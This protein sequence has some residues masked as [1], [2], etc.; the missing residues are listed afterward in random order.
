MV[1]CFVSGINVHLL[2]KR[3]IINSIR[4]MDSNSEKIKIPKVFY[5]DGTGKLFDKCIDCE[6]D[7][8]DG[9]TTYLI[10]KAV[11]QFPKFDAKDTIFEYAICLNCSLKLYASFS[12]E[13]RQAMDQYFDAHANRFKNHIDKLD[14]ENFEVNEYLS[15][16][17]MKG[18]PVKE[19]AEYQIICQCRGN[20]LVLTYPP[21]LVGANAIDEVANLLSNKTIDTLGGFMDDNLGLPPEIKDILKDQPVFVF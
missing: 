9:H 13:S 5:S 10:E 2:R 6:C 8:L 3:S 21:Y 1:T 17:V 4:I 20:N 15:N 19:L 18:T 11:K 7:L 16:C 12:K 14:R